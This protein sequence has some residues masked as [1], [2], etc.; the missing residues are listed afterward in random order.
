MSD[1]KH[2][3]STGSES[4]QYKKDRIR[5]QTISAG[6]ESEPDPSHTKSIGSKPYKNHR[7]QAIKK[8]RIQIKA[9]QKALGPSHTKSTGSKPYKKQIKEIQ[10]NWILAK[11]KA[12][13]PCLT[14]SSGSKQYKKHWLQIKSIQNALDP[15][16]H[17]QT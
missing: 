5:I 17:Y 3:K 1:P 14:K 8:L 7:T 13:D 16:L 15:F 4:A 6:S 9:I 11:Q 12:P 10:K 2:T